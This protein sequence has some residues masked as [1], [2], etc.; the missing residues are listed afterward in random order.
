LLPS[1]ATALD[2]QAALSALSTVGQVYVY[3]L[4]DMLPP[5]GTMNYVPPAKPQPDG[6]P[7]NGNY[8]HPQLN[9]SASFVYNVVQTRPNATFNSSFCRTDGRQVSVCMYCSIN[10]RNVCMYYECM[11]VYICSSSR[12]YMYVLCI[13]TGSDS[14]IRVH[15]R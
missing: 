2:I 1:T 13:L 5:N 3:F 12:T 4:S 6:E 8:F 14:R 11:Y 10:I 9:G 15:T 7:R